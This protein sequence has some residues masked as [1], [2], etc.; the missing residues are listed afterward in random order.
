MVIS[1]GHFLKS[2][3]LSENSRA[4]IIFTTLILGNK[5]SENK[6]TIVPFL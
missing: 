6:V 1:F 5:K 2:W 4:K 3:N